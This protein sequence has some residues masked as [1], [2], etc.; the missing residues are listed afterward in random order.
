MSNHPDRAALAAYVLGHHD[1][2]DRG[3]I[4]THVGDCEECLDE[5]G[6]EARL[7]LLLHA[8]GRE[9]GFA[10]IA[11]PRPPRRWPLVAAAAVA[12]AAAAAAVALLRP[13]SGADRPASRVAAA[14]EDGA[15]VVRPAGSRPAWARG[16]GSG[17]VR[18]E[19]VDRGLTCV[20]ASIGRVR[21]DAATEAGDL[22]RE[23][24]LERSLSRG[25]WSIAA[26]RAAYTRRLVL[27]VRSSH[28][29]RLAR[30]RHQVVEH[31]PLG[32]RDSW[33]WEE[34]NAIDGQGTEFLVFVRFRASDEEID[35][36]LAGYRGAEVDGAEL[37]PALPT[38]RW[39]LDPGDQLAFF[40]RRPGR[41][42]E[43]G[44]RARDVILMDQRRNANDM[45]ALVE[46]D[47]VV[48]W[49]A[50]LAGPMP[51]SMLR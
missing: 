42:A 51:P 43:L 10:A 18:C 22:A 34:H 31:S 37:V 33:Y 27:S 41:L 44:I 38:I 14:L 12:V 2:I 11:V 21:D 24:L 35:D 9:D 19:E 29:D 7:E 48:V 8:A 4:E 1:E 47:Q 15:P 17:V 46:S 36:F 50:G 39:V 45:R 28:R 26:Q 6:R 13:G 25:G 30:I 40:V 32:R 3:S 20:A 23:A 5:V 16:L 49:R